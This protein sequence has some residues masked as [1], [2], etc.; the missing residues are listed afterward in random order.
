MIYRR[1]KAPLQ[2]QNI[3]ESDSSESEEEEEEEKKV[4][5]QGPE[6]VEDKR[7]S[8]LQGVAAGRMPKKDA[9]NSNSAKT[10]IIEDEAARRARLREMALQKRKQNA[11]EESKPI[12]LPISKRDEKVKEKSVAS[13]ESEESSEESEEEDPYPKPILFKPVFVPKYPYH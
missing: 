5:E 2:A 10:E 8:R 7:L 11:Q 4:E 12:P 9:L 6:K 13:E 3:T 1:G